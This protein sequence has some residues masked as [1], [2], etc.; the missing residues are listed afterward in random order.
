MEVTVE[1]LG[2]LFLVAMLAGW[3]DTLAGGGG[4]IVLPVLMVSGMTPVQALATNKCQG[5]IGTLTAS[6]TLLAKGKLKLSI[7]PPLMFYTC[8]GALLGTWLIQQ[9]S[10]DWLQWFVPVLLLS[11][12]AYFFFVPS[13][14]ETETKAKIKD[15]SWARFVVPVVGF[16]DGFFGPGTGSF[17]AASR[18]A[19]LGKELIES[20][21]IAKPLNFVSNITSLL[22]FAAGGQVVWLV[23]IVMMVGQA[24]GAVLGAHSIYWGGARL[25]RPIVIIMCVAMSVRQLWMLL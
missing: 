5:F 25:I 4:L 10:T 20:T 7:L 9:L 6:V 16:Y 24:L 18:V 15:S 21:V 22:L 23:G 3:V 19:L 8:I 17:F 14:G 12:A 13:I 2:I 1:L 11:I